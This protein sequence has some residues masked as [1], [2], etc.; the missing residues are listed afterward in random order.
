M[1]QRVENGR[2][3]FE[4]EKQGSPVNPDLCEWPEDYFTGDIWFDV[5]PSRP[6]IRTIALDPSKGRDARHG[7]YSAYV[8]LAIDDAGVMY[9]EADL[10]RRPTP[11]IVAD[12]LAHYRD[13]RPDGFTIETNCYQDLLGDEFVR[14]FRLRGFPDFAP[15][16]MENRAAKAVRIRKLGPLLSRRRLRFR[17]NSPG[18]QMLVNQLHDFPCGDH[19]DGPDALEMAVRLA[20][21]LLGTDEAEERT[22][23][24]MRLA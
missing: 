5:W 7:D 20:N 16:T 13:F 17:R 15:F 6:M 21:E 24:R 10:A 18:T 19:D 14:E 4:R 12:G 11:E 2:T 8:L 9:V 1:C 23:E 22:T 3:A